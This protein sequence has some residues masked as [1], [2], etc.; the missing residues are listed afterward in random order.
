[1]ANYENKILMVK[2][3]SEVK[4]SALRTNRMNGGVRSEIHSIKGG[5]RSAIQA[6]KGGVRCAMHLM[7]GGVILY[8]RSQ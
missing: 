3:S 6:M 1:M 7:K 4:T 8:I 2:G 5:V